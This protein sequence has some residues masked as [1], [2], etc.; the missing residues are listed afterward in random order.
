M[1]SQNFTTTF[2]GDQTPEEIFKT[3]NNVRGW[4]SE[5]IEGSTDTLG[6]EFKYHYNDVHRCKMK[7]SEFVLG[8]KAVCHRLGKK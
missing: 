7:T 4:W 1:T 8:Q 5:E 6:A 3:I 2:S